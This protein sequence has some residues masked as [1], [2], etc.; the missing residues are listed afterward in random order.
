MPKYRIKL[1]DGRMVTV[2]AAQ[3]PSEQEVLSAINAPPSSP[4]APQAPARTWTDTAIDAL[5][6]AGGF[7][8]SLVGAGKWNPVGV[9]GA[10]VGG[11]G[12][13][14]LRQI[15][16]AARGSADTP[17]SF[18]EQI[19]RAGTEG[20]IQAGAEGGG[21]LIS[22]G[23]RTVAEP[24]YNFGLGAAKALRREYPAM[25]R[26]AINEGIAVSPR[27]TEKAG[28]LLTRSTNQADAVIAQAEQAGAS[29]IATN[30][31]V[32]GFK[33]VAGEAGK[34]A[35][36][37]Q[38]DDT[39]AIAS[40]AKAI[41]LKNKQGIPL[42]EAQTLKRTAQKSA[43]KAFRAEERGGQVAGVN[44][45]LDLA[46]ARGLKSAIE[47]RVPAVGPINQRSQALGGL[48]QALE[49][50]ET[51]NH[52]LSRLI[53]PV[54]AG[55]TT[56]FTSGDA[57]TGLGSAALTAGLTAPGNLSRAALLMD[58]TGRAR[59]PENLIRAAILARLQGEQ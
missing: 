58:R 48:T 13:E 22:A 47:T 56:G 52:M 33:D 59:L 55:A 14:F 27:G 8:G 51:R 37:G 31:V 11:T 17:T 42:S 38:V 1:S 20:A 44:A 26:T 35:R 50:A 43:D 7:L 25:A 40:R 46:T 2:E 23:L 49:D 19:S 54:A 45:E 39:G 12:G 9:A 18:R 36:L 21:R 15:A 34:R 10:A 6:T 57:K 16:N 29:P 30:E 41:H 24:I 5:P 4:A 3:P 53:V 28:R 32:S